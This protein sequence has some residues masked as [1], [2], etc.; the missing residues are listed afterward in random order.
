MASSFAI[1]NSEMH[2]GASESPQKNFTIVWHPKPV[3]HP[4]KKGIDLE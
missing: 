2:G 1:R 4:P 3:M